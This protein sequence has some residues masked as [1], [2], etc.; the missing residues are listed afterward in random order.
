MATK[1]TGFAGNT[2]II[3]PY[4]GILAECDIGTTNYIL[5]S[6]RVLYFTTG[7]CFD[8]RGSG[9]G[10]GTAR[11][12]CLPSQGSGNIPQQTSSRSPERAGEGCAKFLATVIT[13]Y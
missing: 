3:S 10:P 4:R 5:I 12:A 1:S 9:Q 6:F 7:V 13:K 8:E 11:A 2:V